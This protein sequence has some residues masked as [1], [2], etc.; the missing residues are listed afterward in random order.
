MT[1]ETIT[2][3]TPLAS[4]ASGGNLRIEIVSNGQGFPVILLR[5]N[6]EVVA[7]SH[8]FDGSLESER[9]ATKIRDRFNAISGLNPAAIQDA[10]AVLEQIDSWYSGSL[11]HRPPYVQSAR[12]ALAALKGT[13]ENQ[14]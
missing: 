4:V 7:E 3:Q 2:N 13:N 8:F 10:V 1:P 6:G 12:T 5:E 14:P 11:D 9:A